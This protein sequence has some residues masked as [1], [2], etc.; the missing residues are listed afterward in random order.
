[1]QGKLRATAMDEKSIREALLY[2]CERDEIEG[3]ETLGLLAEPDMW[4]TML[5]LLS[6]GVWWQSG[7]NWLDLFCPVDL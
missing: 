3:L 2:N 7:R 5:L 6:H 1:M 4:Q